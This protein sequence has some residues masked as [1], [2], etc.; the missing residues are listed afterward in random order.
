MSEQPETTYVVSVYE[1]PNWR[2]VLTTNDKAKALAC[3]ERS[4]TTCA[5]RRSLRSQLSAKALG[6]VG[7]ISCDRSASFAGLGLRA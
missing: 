6:E 4:A 5:S 3:R 1:A 2:T 7:D